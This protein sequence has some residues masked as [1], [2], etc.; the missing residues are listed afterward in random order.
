MTENASP[1]IRSLARIVVGDLEQAV[2]GTT[3]AN[4]KETLAM[5]LTYAKDEELVSLCQRLGEQLEKEGWLTE[6]MLCAVCAIDIP[7]MMRLDLQ[8]HPDCSVR[9]HLSTVEALLILCAMTNPREFEMPDTAAVFAHRFAVI[10]AELTERGMLSVT[11]RLVSV[12]LRSPSARVLVEALHEVDPSIV[13]DYKSVAPVPCAQSVAQPVQSVAPAQPKS[14]AQSVAPATS[15]AQPV[16]FTSAPAQSAPF[17]SAPAQPV[18]PKPFIPSLP[19]QPT[20]Q[21][22]PAPQP[23]AHTARPAPFIPSMPSATP[24]ATPSAMPS[25]M[26]AKTSAP[27]VTEPEPVMEDLP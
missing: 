12:L 6:A 13:P 11:S 9:S 17:T 2:A 21:P 20:Y 15:F 10:C 25:S 3:H 19:V 23:A 16:P 26:P 14:F 4:W 5:I 27:A 22:V 18:M 1:L 24:S 7:A 8:I